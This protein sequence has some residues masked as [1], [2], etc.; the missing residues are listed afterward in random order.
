MRRLP[1]L[2]TT[3]ALS[4]AA[5]AQ[6]AAAVTLRPLSGRGACAAGRGIPG[7]VPVRGMVNPVAAAF[8]GGGRDLYVGSL[9]NGALVQLHRDR[10][11]GRL[12]PI[13]GVPHCW[14]A[15]LGCARP[16]AEQLMPDG[17][18]I[19]GDEQHLYVPSA[20]NQ[21]EA[22]AVGVIGFAR[23]GR[24]GALRPLPRGVV[25]PR[26]GRAA[27]S[28][29]PPRGGLAD[30]DLVATRDGRFLY[31]ASEAGIVVLARDPGS[32]ALRQPDGAAGCLLTS[33]RSPTRSGV[34]LRDCGA[35]KAVGLVRDLALSPDGRQLYVAAEA[36]DGRGGGLTVLRR[37]PASGALTV[38][39]T[40]RDGLADGEATNVTVA[41]D[42]AGVYATDGDFAVHVLRRAR[43]DGRLTRLRGKAGCVSV[44]P[45]CTF[46]RATSAP[47]EIALTPNGRAAFL[48]D[49]SGLDLFS[50]AGSGALRQ[51]RTTAACETRDGTDGLGGGPRICV[52]SRLKALRAGVGGLAVTPDGRDLLVLG[53]AS[54]YG[55]AVGVVD[56]ARI[57]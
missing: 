20:D 49:A 14:G 47:E 45:R 48:A 5:V 56:V 34:E 30:G 46:P 29:L 9:G 16:P 39:Q 2:L 36:R 32:G 31:G 17:I 8:A 37:D 55:R 23:D 43:G 3:F 51:A 27:G 54:G 35:A 7:C 10:R 40:V 12:S 24:S 4:A 52:R 13:A 25:C 15:Q 22:D 21:R 28:C 53:T 19:P 33:D 6:P 42:G 26:P 44:D 1:L 11:S 38:V 57:G 50:R 41:P 18:A